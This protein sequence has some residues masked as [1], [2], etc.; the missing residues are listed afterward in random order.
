MSFLSR[1]QNVL[2]TWQNQQNGMCVQRRLRSGWASEDWSDWADSQADLSLCWAHRSFCWFCHGAAHFMSVIKAIKS[3]I[4]HVQR[5]KA[6]SK[7]YPLYAP[8]SAGT[9]CR[10]LPY[11]STVALEKARIVLNHRRCPRAM[12]SRCNVWNSLLLVAI[13]TNKF[14]MVLASGVGI[15]KHLTLYKWLGWPVADNNG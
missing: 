5:T 15:S 13:Y 11:Y 6:V 14:Y 12:S 2:D 9:V 7:K 8:F 10:T 1:L 4:Y 3:I